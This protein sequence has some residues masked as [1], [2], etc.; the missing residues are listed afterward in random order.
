MFRNRILAGCAASALVLVVTAGGSQAYG[1]ASGGARSCSGSTSYVGVQ[2]RGSVVMKVYFN[3][4]LKHTSSSSMVTTD[5]YE[6][7]AHSIS[8][9]QVTASDSINSSETYSYCYNSL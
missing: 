2:Y 7:S 9:W 8:S 5:W 3:G 6:S 4:V 1:T